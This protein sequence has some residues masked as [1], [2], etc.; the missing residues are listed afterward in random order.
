MTFDGTIA[1]EQ[2]MRHQPVGRAL[3]L[4][5]LDGLAESQRLGLGEAHWPAGMS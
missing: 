3:G 5:L 4:D 1:L 2:P